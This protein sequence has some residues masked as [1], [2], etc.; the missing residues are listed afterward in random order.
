MAGSTLHYQLQ[1]L[2]SGDALSTNSYKFTS[3]DRQQIDTLLYLGA[4][5]HH[6]TGAAANSSST[7]TAPTLTLH[8]SGGAM[9]AATRVYYAYTYVDVNGHETAGS[10]IA[11]VDTPTKV[12]EPAAP[13][14][15]YASTGGVLN[16]GNYYYALSAYTVSSTSETLAQ[17]PVYITIPVGTATNEVVLTMPSLPS[18]ATGFNI[19]RRKPGGTSYVFLASTTA[20]SYTDTGSV[21]EDPNRN[22]PLANVT[23]SQNYIDIT[24]PG[25][26]V[27]AGQ[28]WKVYRSF[29]LNNWEASLLNWVT[30]ETFEGSGIITPT[31]SDLGVGTSTGKPPSVAQQVGSPAKVLLTG[32][33]EV[34]GVLPIAN[35][36]TGSS[37]VGGI[38]NFL[39]LAADT[40]SSNAVQGSVSDLSFAVAA[41]STYTFDYTLFYEAT[42]TGDI[43]FS[44]SLPSGATIQ[45]SGHGL[46]T[47]QATNPG[48]VSH[49]VSTAA[50]TILVFGG[51]GLGTPLFVMGHGIIT[52]S[53]TSGTAT[54]NF[55]QSTLDGANPTKLRAGT[56]GHYWKD[57]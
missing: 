56:F 42:A 18:G 14:L 48:T 1:T 2:E 36:G 15:V 54:F 37:S 55:A 57:A 7:T 22:L 26:T 3:A 4:E 12:V 47:T 16:P 53:S 44:W 19:Y 30:D 17:N 38:A 29:S 31:F 13:S 34:Q 20:S 24:V 52:V 45:W 28:T 8:T 41:N 32:G 50:A 11:Y 23:N 27:P 46:A 51:V 49:S 39:K 6:H 25:G 21:A 35:G 43:G 10:T 9:P 33:A 5:G 40:T